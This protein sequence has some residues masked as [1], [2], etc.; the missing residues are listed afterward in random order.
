MIV[1][2]CAGGVVFFGDSVFLLKNDKD[3]WVMPK[4][5]LRD[6]RPL[7]EVALERVE[8]EAGL[9]AEIVCEAGSTVYEFYSRTRR[10]PVC[11][12]ITWYLM[13]TESQRYRIAFEQ[14]FTD[15]DWFPI[16]RALEIVTYTQDREL[17]AAAFSRL[18]EAEAGA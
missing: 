2:N 4:G 11:N 8:D 12:R 9:K 3:E 15:G 5:V 18:T 17:L 6:R 10:Q 7:S 14:G 13:K 16:D 1:R